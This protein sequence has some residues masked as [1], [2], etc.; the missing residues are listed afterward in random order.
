MGILHLDYKVSQMKKTILLFILLSFFQFEVNAQNI[1]EISVDSIHCQ[2]SDC[3]L[4]NIEDDGFHYCRLEAVE[5]SQNKFARK[6]G[7]YPS[8]EFQ[9]KK[10]QQNLLNIEKITEINDFY[11]WLSSLK[12]ECSYQDQGRNYT[13]YFQV[14]NDRFGV[15]K[16]VGFDNGVITS[17]AT[18][19][20]EILPIKVNNQ[21][22]IAGIL[23]ISWMEVNQF[24]FP[25]KNSSDLMYSNGRLYKTTS[26]TLSQWDY[27]S[28]SLFRHYEI[29]DNESKK[30][31]N[32][33]ISTNLLLQESFD[34]IILEFPYV[35]TKE[36]NEV[37]IFDTLLEDVTPKNLKEAYPCFGSL[38]I[39]QEGRVKYFSPEGEIVDSMPPN[40]MSERF[41]YGIF[42]GIRKEIM[43]ENDQFLESIERVG[44]VHYITLPENGKYLF[45]L[46]EE[47]AEIKFLNNKNIEVFYQ[48]RYAQF[49]D[50]DLNLYYFKT[51]NGY[52]GIFKR[53][54]L[55]EE[56]LQRL[57]KNKSLPD[58][59]RNR[60]TREVRKNERHTF[61]DEIIFT[62]KF[63]K[64]ILL[65]YDHPVIFKKDNLYGI[66]PQMTEG[67]FKLIKPFVGNLAE[68]IFEDGEI[69]WIDLEGKE[70]RGRVT[71][72]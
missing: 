41:G 47:I 57:W 23:D 59:T 35:I 45:N 34:E 20:C 37:K 39:I 15:K 67:R 32:S 52:E 11:Q 54:D 68:V 7:C 38:Q 10:F 69:G 21:F 66:F 40:Y 49:Y 27:V 30:Q 43:K 65:G 2:E 50:M 6:M 46:D 19:A 48:N 62:G 63:E 4:F 55:K 8:N 44:G 58:D 64:L 51:K 13:E 3:F 9:K 25:G 14:V 36:N 18:N 42:P 33:A 29:V 70:I 53:I 72:K 1:L 16:L 28:P 22:Y 71:N 12:F 24:I 26:D 60:L 61:R 56:K 17:G 31:L 5:I